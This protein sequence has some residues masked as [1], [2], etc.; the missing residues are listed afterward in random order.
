LALKGRGGA[1]KRFVPSFLLV[2]SRQLS[3]KNAI[4]TKFMARALI[5][6]DK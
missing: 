2:L 6:L 1:G 5:F 3:K 4:A